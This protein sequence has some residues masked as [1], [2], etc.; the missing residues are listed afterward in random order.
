M[1]KSY[2]LFVII[3]ASLMFGCAA[4][5]Y[6]NEDNRDSNG[7]S[8]A[9]ENEWLSKSDDISEKI[10]FVD[11]KCEEWTNTLKE[12][13]RLIA[14]F[15]QDMIEDSIR[16]VYEEKEGSQYIAQFELLSGEGT[17]SFAIN[18]Y[19]ASFQ[20][21]EM[22][23]IDNDDRDEMLLLFDTHGGGGEGTHDLYV[24]WFSA[25][26][27]TDQK[28]NTLDRS[29]F[30]MESSWNVDD[31]YDIDR[32]EFEDEEKLLVRQYVWGENGHSDAIGNLMSM[33]SFDKE[34]NKFEVGKCWLE[35]RDID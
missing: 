25:D 23:D 3:I 15:N 8:A 12:N 33:V 35:K 13:G 21:I 27:I 6:G 34:L 7:I 2:L 22:F 20:K 14:D 16:I 4:Q 5:E 31:I 11:D 18:D 28:I 32:I 26:G 9:A 30:P 10:T 29:F 19:D 17:D 1:K 24:I